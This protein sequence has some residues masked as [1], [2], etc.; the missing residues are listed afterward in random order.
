VDEPPVAPNGDVRTQGRNGDACVFEARASNGFV[1]QVQFFRVVSWC[2]TRENAETQKHR[3]PKRRKRERKARSDPGAPGQAPR[4]RGAV[5][6][7]SGSFYL[8]HS[9]LTPVATTVCVRSHRLRLVMARFRARPYPMAARRVERARGS[10][11]TNILTGDRSN[12][13]LDRSP[14]RITNYGL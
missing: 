4:R 6:F 9:E 10:T 12:C 1:L 2:G 5:G 14:R 11:T 8:G 3:K 7:D 13:G